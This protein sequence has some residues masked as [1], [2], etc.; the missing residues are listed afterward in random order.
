MSGPRCPQSI[1]RSPPAQERCRWPGAPVGDPGYRNLLNTDSETE[2]GPETDDLHPGPQPTRNP[3]QRPIL[4]PRTV[5]RGRGHG[6]PPTS[7]TDPEGALDRA[8]SRDRGFPPRFARSATSRIRIR[9]LVS[10]AAP[11]I[12]CGL[13]PGHRSRSQPRSRLP[14]LP[15]PPSTTLPYPGPPTAPGWNS[16]APGL[17]SRRWQHDAGRR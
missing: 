15:R 8:T 9:K 14:F 5:L 10:A 6:R 7:A 4:Q 17:S 3:K 13:G 1:V 2:T 11:E 12:G 16:R